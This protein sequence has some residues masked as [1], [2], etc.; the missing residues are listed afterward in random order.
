MG[1]FSLAILDDRSERDNAM[2]FCFLG[3]VDVAV[4]A[5]EE[6]CRIFSGAVDRRTDGEKEGEMLRLAQGM[7]WA[8]VTWTPEIGPGPRPAVRG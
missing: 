8:M 6:E 5:L 4:G 2:A 3:G 1:C 7:G